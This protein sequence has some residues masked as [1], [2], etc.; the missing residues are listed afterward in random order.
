MKEFANDLKSIYHASTEEKAQ[1]NLTKV[2]EKQFEKYPYAMKSWS[3][4]W[5][6][7]SP[8]FKFSADVRKVISLNS[9]YRRL[10][11]SRS[12]YPSKTSLLKISLFF[13]IRSS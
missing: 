6:V 9:T 8:I 3:A 2:T 7:I 11:R 13:N 4:N 1:E 5:D 10:N 12:V